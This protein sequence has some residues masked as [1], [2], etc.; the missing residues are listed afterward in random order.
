MRP[1]SDLRLR[2]TPSSSS[3]Q[4][5]HHDLLRHGWLVFETAGQRR[6]LVP[7][8]E[9]W[10]VVDEQTLEQLCARAEQVPPRR[11]LLD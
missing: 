4:P 9:N 5:D 6:R 8:P 11:R 1:T 7:I 10:E 3:A 2:S